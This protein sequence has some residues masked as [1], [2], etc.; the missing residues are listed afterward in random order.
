MKSGQR[1]MNRQRRTLLRSGDVVW[2]LSTRRTASRP[3]RPGSLPRRTVSTKMPPEVLPASLTFREK[4]DIALLP[5]PAHLFAGNSEVRTADQQGCGG[6]AFSGRC[7]APWVKSGSV[8][9]TVA[10]LVAGKVFQKSVARLPTSIKK[11]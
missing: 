5:A 7:G 3:D 8:R 2:V 10:S 11:C 9:Y 6:E 1:G 4:Q